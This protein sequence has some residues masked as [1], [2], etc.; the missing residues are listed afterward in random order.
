MEK[1]SLIIPIHNILKRGFKRVRNSVVSLQSQMEYI[2]DIIIVDSSERVQYDML[3]ALLDGFKV[4]HIHYPL[5]S[6]NKPKL[7]NYG[8][9]EANSKY[10]MCT[11]GDYLFKE[12]FL[13]I[14]S[15]HRRENT[16][17][18]KQV[19]MLP[20][21]NIRDSKIKEWKF[22][23]CG[24]NIWGKL[25]N[26][27]VQYATKEFFIDNPYPEEME[28]FT[29]MDNLMTY[30]AYNNG[31][32]IHWIQESEILHQYHPIVNKMAGSNREKTDKNQATLQSYIN[33][34]Q[35]PCLLHK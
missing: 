33:E 7:L 14:C 12:D 35:L 1:V 8:I 6:F 4:R 13:Y 31:L 29:A 32:K 15:V 3:H 22:P 25:A 23:A 26:G 2:D 5:H 20:N 11:D 9:K 18:H 21:M 24:Y 27:A 34:H 16:M 17:M 30:M 19:K 28:G 10:I